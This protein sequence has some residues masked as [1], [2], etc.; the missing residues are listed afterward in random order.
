MSERELYQKPAVSQKQ[1]AEVSQKE[2][3]CN[4][5]LLSFIEQS[6]TAFHATAELKKLLQKHYYQELPENVRWHL[7]KGGTYF[8]T[9]NGSSIIA[10]RIP[11]E[12]SEGMGF[13]IAASHSD[14]PAF[15]IKENP[16]MSAEGNYTKLN[17]EKYGGMICAPWFDRPLSIAGRILCETDNG[18]QTRLVDFG[19]D[20]VLI[21]NVAI[22]MNR[23]VNEGYSYNVQTDLLPLY[24]D[25]TAKGTFWSKTAEKAGVELRKL[26]GSDLF[27]YNRERGTLWGVEKKFLSAPRLD[28]LQCAFAAMRGLLEADAGQS[29]AMC[30]VFDNEEVGSATK[31]GAESDFFETTLRRIFRSLGKDSEDFDIALQ[32]SFM[33]SA[34]NAHAVHPNHSELAD[35]TN[36]PYLNRGIVIKFNANQKYTTDGVSEAVFRKICDHAEVPYQYFTNRS[37]IAGGSTLGNIANTKV[38]MNTVDIGLPQLAMH[39]PYETTGAKD[40]YALVRAMREF[41][42]CSIQMKT[43]GS[44]EICYLRDHG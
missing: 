35:P 22:H 27:L 18:I 43:P 6:P 7:K 3:E 28:D 40:T 36:R 30:A 14:S 17:A 26:L 10:F 8:T 5:A 20:Q 39:S 42:S 29:I 2:Q 34:D 4:Q 9:R 23:K 21:P 12:I 38:S 13:Q 19:E 31:Q 41:F 32:N 25:E 37:D 15:K 44:Y 24:G 33:V 11:E 1:I 16:E